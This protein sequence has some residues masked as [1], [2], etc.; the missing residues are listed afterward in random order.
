MRCAKGQSA[1]GWRG[2]ARE[3]RGACV[4]VCGIRP[5]ELTPFTLLSC[6]MRWGVNWQSNCLK[7]HVSDKNHSFIG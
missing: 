5:P 4:Y 2:Q 7:V 1:V 3:S 6:K